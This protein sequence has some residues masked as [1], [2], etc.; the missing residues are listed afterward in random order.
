MSNLFSFVYKGALTE[1]E[2]DTVN[3]VP[4]VYPNL[5]G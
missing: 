4:I 3:L 1:N 5:L 2:K